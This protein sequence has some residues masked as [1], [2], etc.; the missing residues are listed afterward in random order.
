V[1]DG[2]APNLQPL[3]SGPALAAGIVYAGAGGSVKVRDAPLPCLS[4]LF[5]HAHAR[6]PRCQQATIV[7][8]R[9]LYWDGC[10][11]TIN[12]TQLA[13]RVARQR[14][15]VLAWLEAHPSGLAPPPLPPPQQQQQHEPQQPGKRQK[16]QG[17][18]RAGG[19]ERLQSCGSCGVK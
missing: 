6:L 7:D 18:T 10:H 1:L 13:A 5:R 15:R 16:P 11:A 8:G 3:F 9:L 2:S 12:A 19:R 17:A 14:A 4:L